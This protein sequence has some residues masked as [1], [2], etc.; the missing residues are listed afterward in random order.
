RLQSVMAEQVRPPP[1][2]R[3]E[4]GRGLEAQVRLGVLAVRPKDDAVLPPRGRRPRL[5]FDPSGRPVNVVLHFS[6]GECRRVG[7]GGWGQSWFAREPTDDQY[8]GDGH[9]ADGGEGE[10]RLATPQSADHR[11]PS[12]GRAYS[13]PPLR[14]HSANRL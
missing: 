10:P 2:G 6:V 7:A 12:P 14:P 8:A 4:V 9:D 1:V 3:V 11:S 13:P 5:E